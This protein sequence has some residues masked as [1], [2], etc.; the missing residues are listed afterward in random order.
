MLRLE[1]AAKTDRGLVRQSNQDVAVVVPDL[2]LAV[3]ADGVGGH[4]D[5][6]VASQLA[7]TSFVEVFRRLGGPAETLATTCDRV[8]A[9]F[10]LANEGI[11]LHASASGPQGLGTTLVVA[12]FAGAHAIV[13][14]VGDS[15]CYRLRTELELLTEDHSMAAEA[16]RNPDRYTVE[17]FEVAVRSINVLTRCVD[18]R[19]DL[20]IDMQVISVQPEDV[21]LLCSDGLWGCVKPEMIGAII[22]T[23]DDPED[24]CARMIEAAC[25]GGGRDNIAAAIVHARPRVKVVAD[26]DRSWLP[27]GGELRV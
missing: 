10:R 16:K 14:N 8:L 25:T 20:S 9:A 19:P 22:R 27:I 17:Q 23:S 3:V 2:Q 7:V 26:N 15:R 6:E 1:L 4:R 5:G 18:G 12:V 11:G 24:A 13:A 21:F